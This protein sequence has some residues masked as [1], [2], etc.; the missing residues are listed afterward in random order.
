MSQD[1]MRL[2]IQ[3]YPLSVKYPIQNAR[4]PNTPSNQYFLDYIFSQH[5]IPIISFRQIDVEILAVHFLVNFFDTILFSPILGD[6]VW[7]DNNQP[8]R[9]TFRIKRP[10]TS[11]I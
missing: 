11:T 1:N 2:C 7:F 9:N 8:P 10:H 4:K 6:K 5:P 3:S